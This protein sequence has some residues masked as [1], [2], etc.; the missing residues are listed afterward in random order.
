V[1]GWLG[2]FAGLLA[3]GPGLA[4]AAPDVAYGPG[5]PLEQV[6]PGFR[7]HVRAVLAQPTLATRGPAETFNC[8]P[9]VY[10][11][12]L[13]HPDQAVRLWYALGAG[14]ALVEDRGG[15]VFGWRDGQGSDVR[16]QS[17]LNTAGQRLWY[18]EGRVKPGVLLPTIGF[19]AV[20]VLDYTEGHDREG[21][22]ALRHQMHMYLHTDSHA[23]ALAAKLVGASAPRLAEQ[24]V[25]QL[26]MFF[27]GMA[28]YLDQDPTRTRTLLEGLRGRAALPPDAPA[29]WSAV[30]AEPAPAAR[31][32]AAPGRLDRGP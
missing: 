22:P 24:Y 21:R 3:A 14:C 18:A 2:V 12:L 19:Q 29:G 9:A 17:V 10:H 6:A 4:R 23:A 13:D 30:L 11:W 31:A 27:G 16:W 32:P 1:A 20:V 25:A 28:W 26:E 8:R 7:D 5:V 15:G